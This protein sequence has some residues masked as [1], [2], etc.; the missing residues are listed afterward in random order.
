MREGIL[1]ICEE[2]TN[3]FQLGTTGGDYYTKTMD[4]SKK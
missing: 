3:I 4:D 1:V 2:D